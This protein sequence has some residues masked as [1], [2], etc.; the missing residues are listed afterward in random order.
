VTSEKRELDVVVVEGVGRGAVH[1]RGLADAG[2]RAAADEGGLGSTSLFESLL[3]RNAPGVFPGSGEGHSQP[4][5]HA[6][7]CDRAYL[8]RDLVVAE[9][10][11][12]SGERAGKTIGVGACRSVFAGYRGHLIFSHVS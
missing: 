4:V 11:G 3:S 6:V 9:I 8:F 1:Q 12:V 5:E 7:P 10:G 2:A